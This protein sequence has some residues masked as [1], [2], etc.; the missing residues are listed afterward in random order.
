MTVVGTA[1]LAL[2][3]EAYQQAQLQALLQAEKRR[4]TVLNAAS[5][6]AV[7]ADDYPTLLKAVYRRADFAKP[8]NLVG[9]A[10]NLSVT[11]ME[12]LLLTHLPATEE[13]MRELALQRGVAVRDYLAAQKLPLERLFLGAAKTAAPEAKWQPHAELNVSLD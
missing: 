6:A 11:E 8:R 10:K 12:A 7:A 3:R 4:A 1:S 13:S 2:E 9:L 5:A